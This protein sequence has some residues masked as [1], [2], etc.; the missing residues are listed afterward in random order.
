MGKP[1]WTHKVRC[2]YPNGRLAVEV[3]TIGQSVTDTEVRAAKSRMAPDYQGR[4]LG[5]IEVLEWVGPTG[6]GSWAVIA[7]HVP[8]GAKS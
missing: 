1:R 3:G 4:K 5:K 7:T 8:E 2:Y 6:V